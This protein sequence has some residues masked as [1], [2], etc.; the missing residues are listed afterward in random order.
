MEQ[1]Q[2]MPSH[3]GPK[4]RVDDI[5]YPNETIKLLLE[6][7]SSRS[8]LDRK[9]EPEILDFILRAGCHAPT[10]GNLQPYSII[11]IEDELMRK[12]IAENAEQEF[13][14]G[15]TVL[16]L[17][18]IDW[19]RLKRWAELE[20]APFTATASFRH[21]WISFQDVM[22]CAQNICTAADSFGLGSVYIG[23]V[24]DFIEWLREKLDLPPGVFPVVLLALGYPKIN[25][26]SRKKLP[27]SVVVYNEK[28]RLMSDEEIL[29]AFKEKYSGH[30]TEITEE[31]IN[32]IEEVC[33]EVHGEEFA[34]QCI[35]KI[36]EN[37]FISQVQRYFGLHY[38][39]NE[40]PL[41]NENYLKMFEEAGFSW[42]KD[43]KPEN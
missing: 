37:G 38:T 31:N 34:K 22:I 9:I 5:D 39:A 18:C 21:F 6:R 2:N 17:F 12:N 32:T 8:F 35:E 25:P 11:K 7:G 40:M 16:L 36:K 4:V 10:G 14:A 43:F 15:A 26:L 19:C 41:G 27:T 13:L 33:R 23:T 28:Y 1:N 24:I 29:R 30:K 3:H 42:F 20:A